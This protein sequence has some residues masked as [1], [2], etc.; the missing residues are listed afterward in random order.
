MPN[1]REVLEERNPWWRGQTRL[2][3]HERSVY[4]TVRRYMDRRQ[5]L[6]LT[7]LR[8]VGK[9]TL[10]LKAAQDAI[11]EGLD[12]LDVVYFSF[13][14]FRDAD[15]RD[16][17]RAYERVTERD[18]RKGR[19]LVLLDEIQKL[20]GW[21][22]QVKAIYDTYPN[23][24]LLVSGSE[25][26]FI[27]RGSRETLAGRMFEFHVGPLTFREYLGFLGVEIE[28]VGVRERELGRRFEAFSRTQGFPELVG[29]TDRDAVRRYV[30]EAIVQRVVFRDLP[31]L[32]DIRDLATLEAVMNILM[33]EPGQI[34]RVGDLSQELDVNRHTLSDYLSYLEDSFLLHKLYNFSR[35][36]RK[37][38]R[39]LKR[40]YP[41]VLSTDLL[42]RQDDD[43]RS[44]VFEWV[45]VNQLRPEF[46][47]RDPYK[48]EVDAVL[49]DDKDEPVP[50]EVKWGRVDTSG[51]ERFMAKFGVDRGCVVTQDVEATRDV[52]AGT[53]ELVPAYKFLLEPTRWIG[54]DS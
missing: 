27:R 38:E 4:A 53:V 1:V 6:A 47:W 7:G 48:H 23:L 46:F 51:L 11:Q 8:R 24:K 54:R 18:L 30:E 49:G 35:N 3:Y 10:L 37:T 40:F 25:S 36:R 17:L 14:E 33:A 42:Y 28:P 50:V 39:K 5:V 16:V 44:R 52:D 29:E 9:T 12:P 13:D 32:L 45:V 26:L 34:V 43:A 2:D 15:V 22:D 31:T 41:A 21:G 19:K 20:V